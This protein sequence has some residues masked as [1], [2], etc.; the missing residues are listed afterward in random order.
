MVIMAAALA[1]LTSDRPRTPIPEAIR[2]VPTAMVVPPSV[3][4]YADRVVP[5]FDGV[6]RID[7]KV[8]VRLGDVTGRDVNIPGVSSGTWAIAVAGEI[9]A[10]WGLLER[11]NAECAVWFVDPLGEPVA[12]RSSGRAIC[13]PYFAAR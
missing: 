1:F 7:R 5:F 8:I 9:A 10:T 13:E 3:Q 4:A 11:P 2:P 12:F 6:V